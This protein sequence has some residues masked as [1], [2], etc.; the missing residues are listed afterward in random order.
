MGN[1]YSIGHGRLNVARLIEILDQYNITLLVDVRSKPYSRFNPGFNKNRLIKHLGERYLW[2]GDK[3][4]GLKDRDG[5]YYKGLEELI[6]LSRDQNICVM[7]AESDPMKCHREYWIA[8][9]LSKRDINV[10]H[11]LRDGSV[12]SHKQ[13]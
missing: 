11:I 7:C 13:V 5:A 12:L 3:L 2:A 10:K 9:D 4:G 8:R 6:M 1:I